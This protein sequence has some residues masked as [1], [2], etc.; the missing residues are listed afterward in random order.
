MTILK[1]HETKEY[2]RSFASA[3]E[4]QNELDQA[5]EA[6]KRAEAEAERVMALGQEDPKR[7][8][9]PQAKHTSMTRASTEKVNAAKQRLED[10][11]S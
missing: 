1:P 7:A 2:V 4:H 10:V 9:V 11:Q 5:W 3:S 8:N 6:V